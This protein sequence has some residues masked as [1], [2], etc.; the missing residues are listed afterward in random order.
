MT[1]SGGE[2]GRLSIV[3]GAEVR[4]LLN[5][6]PKFSEC[7]MVDVY[8]YYCWLDICF[9]SLFI[10]M[11]RLVRFG[12]GLAVYVFLDQLETWMLESL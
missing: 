11:Y 9:I 1:A 6:N 2:V 3:G 12:V 5:V 10:K 4:K 8:L 7:K